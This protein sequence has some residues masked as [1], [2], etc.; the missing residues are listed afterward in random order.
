MVKTTESTS[1]KG[2][3]G[4]RERSGDMETGKY[5]AVV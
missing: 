2:E 1:A 4:K 5:V 3:R